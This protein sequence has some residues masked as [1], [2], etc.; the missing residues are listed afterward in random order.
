MVLLE[1]LKVGGGRDKLGARDL[2]IHNTI[3]Q[4]DQQDFLLYST[5]NYIKYLI[6]TYSGK[7][8]ERI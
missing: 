4:I 2:Q 3:Y 7:E 1:I 5:G 8:S 6:I